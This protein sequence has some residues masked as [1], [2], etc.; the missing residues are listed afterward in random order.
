[1]I[2][3]QDINLKELEGLQEKKILK[4]E[5]ENGKGNRN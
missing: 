5:V 4:S 2:Q 1:M 3:P